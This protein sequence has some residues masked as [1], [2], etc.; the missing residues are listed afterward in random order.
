[1]GAFEYS[2]F[3]AIDFLDAG[4]AFLV[5]EF[6]ARPSPTSHLGHLAGADLCYALSEQLRGV[7]VGPPEV[8]EPNSRVALFP[9]EWLRDPTS[10]FLVTTRH[11]VPWDDPYLLRSLVVKGISFAE[12][13]CPAK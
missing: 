1:M 10:E 12:Q 8:L 11:D 7:P 13:L 5:L 6:N 9:A 4:D 2:G 3:A